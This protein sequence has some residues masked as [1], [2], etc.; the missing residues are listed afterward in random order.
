MKKRERNV[1]YKLLLFIILGVFVISII[2][3]NVSAA[4]DLK[5]V[6]MNFWTQWTI[7]SMDLVLLKYLFLAIITILIYSALAFA[8]F[9][10]QGSLRFLI[11][12]I[13]SIIATT[14]ITPQQFYTIAQGYGALGITLSIIFPFLILCFFTIMSVRHAGDMGFIMQYVSW[15]VFAVYLIWRALAS[16][17]FCKFDYALWILPSFFYP[18]GCTW[19]D[20]NIDSVVYVVMAIAALVSV[21]MV[22]FNTRIRRWI[23]MGWIREMNEEEKKQFAKFSIANRY[24]SDVANEIL[25]PK[26]P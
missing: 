2:A 11:A 19:A 12:L 23:L 18:N 14:Y 9:P 26:K 5:S 15:I 25:N 17:A 20:P 6:W 22:I 24:F 16:G 7:G 21:L 13:V 10:K 1:N 3:V 4:D 8:E